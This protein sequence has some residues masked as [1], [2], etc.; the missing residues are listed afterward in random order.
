MFFR[1]RSEPT[2]QEIDFTT[3]KE[4]IEEKFPERSFDYIGT[5]SFWRVLEYGPKGESDFRKGKFVAKELR[6]GYPTGELDRSNKALVENVA[7]RLRAERDFL[8]ERFDSELPHL[9]PREKI[10][11]VPPDKHDSGWKVVSIQEKLGRHMRFWGSDVLKEI[12]DHDRDRV[13]EELSRFV[14]IVKAMSTNEY[15]DNPD[16]NHAIPDI[17]HLDNLYLVE[18]EDGFHIRLMDTNFVFPIDDPIS[19]K[20]HSAE[21]SGY[22]LLYLETHILGR[23]LDSFAND[24]FYARHD[25]FHRVHENIPGV[26]TINEWFEL[27]DKLGFIGMSL[28]EQRRMREQKDAESLRL[29]QE[30]HA[31]VK[32]IPEVES[33]LRTTMYG[34]N[35]LVIRFGNRELIVFSHLHGKTIGVSERK[36][37]GAGSFEEL[38]PEMIEEFVMREMN[39]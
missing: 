2:P 28:V 4:P 30:L 11:C 16:F 37:K 32:A 1:R 24:P 29:F 15:T 12:P 27:N 8:R 20:H 6:R 38:D 31:K 14:E 5:G 23:S 36:K 34:H 21:R 39:A 22:T 10:L 33:F 13:L 19:R 35:E 17:T 3:G 18:E 7:K 9:I 25:L 26:P